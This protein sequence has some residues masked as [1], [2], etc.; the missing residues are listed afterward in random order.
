MQAKGSVVSEFMGEL[1]I[2]PLIRPELVNG[3]S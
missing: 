1:R 3:L 2:Q